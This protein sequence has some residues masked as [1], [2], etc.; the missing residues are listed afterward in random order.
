VCPESRC[1]HVVQVGQQA[2]SVVGGRQAPGAALQHLAFS[3]DGSGLV[4]VDVR[5]DAGA[6]FLYLCLLS[7]LT[8][9][10]GAALQQ[11]AFSGDGLVTVDARQD[12]GAAFLYLCLLSCLTAAPGAA[13]Q[14]L[15]FR[16]D[17]GGLVTVNARQDAGAAPPACIYS[18]PL[19]APIQSCRART[20]VRRLALP[21]LQRPCPGA[22]LLHVL[23][24]KGAAFTGL[25]SRV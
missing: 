4:T 14:H 23:I 22:N 3:G 24:S 5:Q 1:A 6:A 10:P 2:P 9:A 16:G 8:A 17:S 13:L 19:H 25:G 7:C 15:A 18:C 21:C 11:L 20:Q 12:A